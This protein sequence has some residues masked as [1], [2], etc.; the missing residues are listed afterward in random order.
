LLFTFF[1]GFDFSFGELGHD[2]L[3]LEEGTDGV[4]WGSTEL[5]PLES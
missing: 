3:L 2:A 1:F 4:A 5:E